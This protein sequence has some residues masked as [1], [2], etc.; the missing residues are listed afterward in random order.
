[1]DAR[2]GRAIEKSQR[3]IGRAKRIESVHARLYEFATG[4]P[5]ARAIYPWRPAH[6]PDDA[7]MATTIRL[8]PEAL[9]ELA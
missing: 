3:I 5:F 2:W 8:E 1:M 9:W 4:P 7:R 6:R